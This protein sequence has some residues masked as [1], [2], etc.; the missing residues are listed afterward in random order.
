MKEP[1]ILIPAFYALWE[2]KKKE[3]EKKE[4][5]KGN[6][7]SAPPSAAYSMHCVPESE[8]VAVSPRVFAHMQKGEWKSS[9]FMSGGFDYCFP[10]LD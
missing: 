3:E 10:V 6:I 4:K 5:K 2:G 7:Y 9:S 8:G 1:L